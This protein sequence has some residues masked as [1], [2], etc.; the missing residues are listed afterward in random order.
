MSF[1]SF[2]F[3]GYATERNVARRIRKLQDV[4]VRDVLAITQYDSL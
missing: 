4:F 3:G 2:I 1:W